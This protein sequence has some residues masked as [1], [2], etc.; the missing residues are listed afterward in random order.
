M[1]R[2]RPRPRGAAWMI[3]PPAQSATDVLVAADGQDA[4]DVLQNEEVDVIFCD[5]RMPNMDGYEFIRALRHRRAGRPAHTSV[6]PD[7]L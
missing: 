2:D 6:P 3:C 5:L 7:S 1:I 4:L